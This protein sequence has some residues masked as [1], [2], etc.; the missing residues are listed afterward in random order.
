MKNACVT[1]EYTEHL[2]M[3][4]GT[5]AGQEVV[6]L[7]ITWHLIALLL[8]THRHPLHHSTW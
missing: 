6:G 7:H 4:W 8:A 3:K 1:L 2:V 5:P